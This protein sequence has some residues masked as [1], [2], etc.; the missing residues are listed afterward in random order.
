MCVCVCVCV[1]DLITLLIITDLLKV[2]FF[3]MLISDSQARTGPCTNNYDNKYFVSFS[4]KRY[5]WIK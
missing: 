3:L 2:T 4:R 1:C 5:D